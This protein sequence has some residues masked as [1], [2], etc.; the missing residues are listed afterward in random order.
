MDVYHNSALGKS[1]YYLAS[2]RKGEAWP[3]PGSPEVLNRMIARLFPPNPHLFA[4]MRYLTAKYGCK[5][6]HTDVARVSNFK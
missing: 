6:L 5:R 2:L 4:F 1:N 3:E